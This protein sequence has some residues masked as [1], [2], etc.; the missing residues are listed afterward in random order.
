MKIFYLLVCLFSF[1]IHAA[2]V[3]FSETSLLLDGKVEPQLW[4]AELQYFRLRGGYG[5]NIPREK[6]IA[7][8]NKALDRMVEAKMNTVSFYIP[9]D[10]HEYAEGKFDFTG[11]VDEDHD[12]NP[13]YP[14]RDLFTFF[15]LI[16]EHGI[17]R[18]MVRPG[19]YINAEWGFLGFGA[20][21]KWFH[22]KFPDSHM[23]NGLG[24]RTRLYDYHHPDFLEY[25]ERWL[26]AVYDQVLKNYMG[27]GRP[28]AFLQIDNETNFMWQSV[29]N[30]DFGNL[31]IKR[32]REFL[33]LR[34]ETIEDLNRAHG[35]NWANFEQ[36]NP[37]K[38]RGFNVSE[39]QDWYRF[40]DW[41]IYTYLQK[42]RSMWER[43][44]V[45]EPTVLFTLAESYNALKDGILPNYE[46]RNAP[47]KTGMMTVNVYPKT[48]ELFSKPLMN[49]PFKTDH[50]VKAADSAN[51]F[52][53]GKKV[54]WVFGPEVQGGWWRGV[55]VSE[56]SRRQTYLSVLGHGMKAIMIY[57]FHEGDNWGVE[58]AF[59]LIRPVFEK[60][61]ARAPYNE[62]TL[63]ELP[64]PFWDE[65]Q[66]TVTE[67]VLYGFDTKGLV[68]NKFSQEKEL[69]FDAPLDGEANPR[70]HY[71]GV[72]EL[73]TKIIAPY[74]EFLGVAQALHDPVCII[75]ENDQ[76]AP[77]K[78]KGIDSLAMNGDWMGGLVGYLLQ[79]N[80]NP[81]I[82][83]WGLNSSDELNE[84]RIVLRQDNG[85][86]NPLLVE[87]L[88]S[89]LDD[90]A[91]VINFLDHSMSEALGFRVKT[92]EGTSKAE[93]V[94]FLF[95]KSRVLISASPLNYYKTLL[96]SDC[97]HTM[98]HN[99]D[100]VGFRCKVGEGTFVQI[101]AL[102]YD[103]FNSDDYVSQTDVP[104]KLKF[105]EHFLRLQKIDTHFQIKEGGDR[106]AIFGRSHGKKQWITVK[107]GQA[108][109]T[110]FH[111][112]ANSVKN[113]KS[114][115]ITNL[116]TGKKINMRG[117]QLKTLGFEAGL[118]PHGSTVYVVKEN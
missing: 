97:Q 20:I 93:W 75:R 39:D 74:Q 68:L 16:E 71:L 73:G 11:T 4:G 57:Y 106:I 95:D 33:K 43:I 116:L 26:K 104:A 45:K 40:Q 84:C 92:R 23:R 112:I 101:G 61:K 36:V 110:K 78:V 37:G 66:N 15:R 96:S 60:I 69:F 44:G 63:I 3:E 113:I 13:D 70:D 91:L 51:D 109:A 28:I 58:G 35:K 32:Y 10:F 14:S 81:K 115:T 118:N 87:K 54:E 62:M 89:L 65:L 90:G 22:D 48:Y 111:I 2:N 76:H 117:L 34:Y 25:S 42:I 19:P 98:Y 102:F 6:V 41:S 53:L 55:D 100:S 17:H 105:M 80:V 7:L 29:W 114:Y 47:G 52:Y 46:Y 12:G 107:S 86:V 88:R 108:N 79:A 5:K 21:P 67:Q 24:F 59:E 38:I 27:P 18:I 99:Q 103:K 94:S 50:D 64:M 8:W 82:H 31:A 72:K 77:T 49:L 83:H 9:W 1:Q 56:D 85:V 30:H